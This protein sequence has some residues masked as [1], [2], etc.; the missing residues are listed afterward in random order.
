MSLNRSHSSPYFEARSLAV[1]GT[2]KVRWHDRLGVAPSALPTDIDLADK[3]EGMLLGLAI[4]DSLGNTS[5]SMNP[6]DRANAH[7]WISDYLPNRNALGRRVGLPGDVPG[8][9]GT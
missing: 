9:V 1:N 8:V 6:I 2:L 5:E 3:V 7:G 4:G